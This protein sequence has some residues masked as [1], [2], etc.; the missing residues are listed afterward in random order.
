M[1]LNAQVHITIDNGLNFGFLYPVGSGGNVI[2]S[3]DGYRSYTGNVILFESMYNPLVFTLLADNRSVKIRSITVQSPITL[4]RT[5]G[6]SMTVNLNVSSLDITWKDLSP[7]YPITVRIGGVLNVGS[8][9]ANPPGRY[10][11]SFYINLNYQ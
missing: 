7:G 5:G 6:G 3:D 10:S 8:I 11:G 2:M 1:P 9:T 4:T